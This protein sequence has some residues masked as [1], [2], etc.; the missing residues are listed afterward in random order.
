MIGLL[1]LLFTMILIISIIFRKRTPF[2]DPRFMIDMGLLVYYAIPGIVYTCFEEY[3]SRSKYAIFINFNVFSNE[4][5]YYAY[6]CIIIF[7]VSFIIG[8]QIKLGKRKKDNEI[9]CV[10]QFKNE[11]RFTKRLSLSISII[12]LVL[13]LLYCSLFGGLTTVMLNIANIREGLIQTETGTY[14]FINKLYNCAPFAVY[15]LIDRCRKEKRY[16]ILVY[17][18]IVSLLILIS[19]GGRGIL[20]TFFLT[21]IIGDYIRKTDVDHLRYNYVKVLQ[22]FGIVIF[23]LVMYRPLLVALGSFQGG[24]FTQVYSD[25]IDYLMSSSRYDASSLDGIFSSIF[26]STTHYFLSLHVSIFK[27]ATDEYTPRYFLEPICILMNIIPSKLLDISKPLTLTYYNSFFIAGVPGLIQIP[28][29]VVGEAFYSGGVFFVCLYGFMIGM[30]GRK[31]LNIYH[32]MKKRV[33]FI[34]TFY[35]GVLFVY[36]HFA[37]GGDYASQFV[38]DFTSLLIIFLVVNRTA[39]T[40]KRC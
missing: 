34:P 32:S 22:I 40:M 17:S 11:R 33:V 16:S 37:I 19:N 3:G 35:V 38:K 12:C 26:Q 13:F 27:V 8:S 29:G 10:V 21:L 9:D 18:L 24:G 31:I 23:M 2:V 15:L 6:L 5:L 28:S 14:D 25:Y 36:F 39:R 4:I 20:L 1:Y 30:I 7:Y